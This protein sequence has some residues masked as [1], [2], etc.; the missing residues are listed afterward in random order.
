MAG[1]AEDI[2]INR[3]KANHNSVRYYRHAK[4]YAIYYF[5]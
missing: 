2:D 1:L 5:R 4:R 3:L